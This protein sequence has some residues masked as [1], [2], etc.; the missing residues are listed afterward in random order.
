MRK[1]T[2]IVLRFFKIKRI[3]CPCFVELLWTAPELLDITDRYMKGT[4]EGDVYSFGIVLHQIFYRMEAFAGREDMTT[5]GLKFE[6]YT[7]TV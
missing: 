3:F 6:M 7:Y 2:I 4:K 5:R 1:Y